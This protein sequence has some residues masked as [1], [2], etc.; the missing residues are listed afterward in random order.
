MG[1]A[2]GRLGRVRLGAGMTGQDVGQTRLGRGGLGWAG[3]GQGWFGLRV[4]RGQHLE[5]ARS[6][7]LG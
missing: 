4:V 1:K 3:L 2:W 6:F 7:G 5:C